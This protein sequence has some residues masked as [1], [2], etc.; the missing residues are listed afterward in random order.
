MGPSVSYFAVYFLLRPRG[1]F[2]VGFLAHITA[3]VFYKRRKVSGETRKSAIN[4][5]RMRQTRERDILGIYL[6]AGN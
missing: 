4:V 2:R 5:L 1:V 6:L 3:F